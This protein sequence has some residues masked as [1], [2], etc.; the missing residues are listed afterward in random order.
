MNDEHLA[1][2]NG[3]KPSPFPGTAELKA[4]CERLRQAVQGLQEEKK[5]DAETLANVQ[6]QLNEYR[7]FL[8]NWARR[9]VR[10]ED[11]QDFVEED[12]TV[13]AEDALKELERQEGP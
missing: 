3:L 7:D 6:A 12:Y 10:K 9:Q 2:D 13:D 8:Y 1:D 4:Q 5:R 11:W